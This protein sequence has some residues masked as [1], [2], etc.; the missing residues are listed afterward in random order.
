MKSTKT[1][2]FILY[3]LGKWFE[4]ANKKIK[5]TSLAVSISKTSFI[6][7]V[8]NSGIAKKQKRAIYKNLE[9]LEKRKLIN[10]KNKEMELTKKGKKLFKEIKADL[11][12]YIIVYKKLKEKSP[13]SYTKKVQTVFK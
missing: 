8:L 3:S 2:R 13:T 10:Y 11:K 5:N 4:E 9:D 1:Q 6:E 7:L 12:P